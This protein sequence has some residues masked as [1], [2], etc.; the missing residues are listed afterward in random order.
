MKKL[1]ACILIIFLFGIFTPNVFCQSTEPIK[2]GALLP[3]TGPFAMWGKTFKNNLE[4]ALSEYGNKVAGRPVELIIED[5]GGQDVTMALSKAKKLVE[6]DKVGVIMGPFY[7]G[8]CLA[9]FPYTAKRPIVALKYASAAENEVDFNYVFSSGVRYNDSTYYLGQYAYDVMNVRS[10]TAIGSDFAAGHDFMQGFI[11]GFSGRG[12]KVVQKQWAP[13]TETDYSPYLSSL[14]MADA[15][16]SSCLGP[17][18][19]I[20]LFKQYQELGLFKK[21]PIILAEAGPIPLPVL[22]QMGDEIIGTVGPNLYLPSLDNEANKKFYPAYM[23]KFHQ[24]PDNMATTAYAAM[25]AVLTALDDTKGNTNAE[26]LA[27]ALSKLELNLPQG[28]F[29][30]NDK[31][32]AAQNLYISKIEK[33]NGKLYWA[34]AKTYPKI[35]P[36]N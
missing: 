10:V 21:M 6:S 11:D 17:Q 4:F 25:I 13:L 36:Y 19:K 15:L 24:I 2:I 26:V 9:V 14:K 22:Q 27:K 30:F 8:S 7:T 16:V 5:E 35:K 12:G 20:V 28:P 33:T 1:F 34:I 3:I 23:E 18:A 29:S 31:R 32:T